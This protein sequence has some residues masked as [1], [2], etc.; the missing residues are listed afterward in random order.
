MIL[1]LILILIIFLYSSSFSAFHS[2]SCFF[3]FPF[4]V[5]LS[6]FSRTVNNF[7]LY[8][9]L[10]SSFTVFL[11]LTLYSPALLIIF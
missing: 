7:P 8:A 11:Y 9:A 5:L 2:I 3:T 1:I 6:P 10:Q 4:S